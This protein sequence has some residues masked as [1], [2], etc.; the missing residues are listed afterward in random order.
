M[1]ARK[2][3]PAL[4]AYKPSQPGD[5]FARLTLFEHL[6]YRLNTQGRYLPIWR[7]LCSCGGTVVVDVHKLR[8][9]NTKSCG[10]L[11]K[12]K[13][14]ANGRDKCFRHGMTATP[15][16]NSW[17]AMLKRCN[18]PGNHAY[19]DYGGRGVIVCSRWDPA[20]G[21]SF[22]NFLSD[23]GERPYGKS[24]DK[25]IRGNGLLYS[26]ETCCWAT[27]KEQCRHRRNTVYGLSGGV[28]LKTHQVAYIAGI[29][30]T[31]AYDRIR[32]GVTGAQLLA[33]VTRKRVKSGQQ[34]ELVA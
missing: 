29:S 6:G 10:C 8:S 21:G 34:L 23:M 18:K 32:R 19:A 3:S 13:A 27:P 28:E 24:L 2:S 17:S 26:P 16:W 33:P 22:E 20:K 31:T 4:K 9:G 14:A 1:G 30:E 15:T 12:E 11:K 25:D 7:C 5:T